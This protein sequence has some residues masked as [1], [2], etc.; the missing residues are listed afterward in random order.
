MDVPE[1]FN[2][3]EFQ[4]WYAQAEDAL[5][6]AQND[7]KSGDYNWCCFKCQQSGEYALKALLRGYG[8][9]AY[10]HSIL[11]L[12]EN[13]EELAMLNIKELRAAA[14]CL[15]RHYIP[16]RYPNAYAAGSPFE[17]YDEST[18]REAIGAARKVLELVNIGRGNQ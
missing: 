10:G 11:K 15:D 7:A 18:A 2:A 6:S 1:F 13:L 8:Q 5:R 16:S 4:R 12:T 17:F 3:K 9:P 14:R